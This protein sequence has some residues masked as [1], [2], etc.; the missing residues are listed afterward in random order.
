VLIRETLSPSLPGFSRA[1]GGGGLGRALGL[2]RRWFLP[3][4]RSLGARPQK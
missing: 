2:M 3:T 1:A 4:V